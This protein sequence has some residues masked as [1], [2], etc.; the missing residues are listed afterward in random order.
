MFNNKQ[1]INNRILNDLITKFPSINPYQKPSLEKVI[2]DVTMSSQEFSD[3]TSIFPLLYSIIN[4]TGQ[5]PKIKYAKNSVASFK[6]RKG[7]EIGVL[8]TLRNQKLLNFVKI[9]TLIGLPHLAATMPGDESFKSKNPRGNFYSSNWSLGI[10]ELKP[11]QDPIFG[12]LESLVSFNQYNGGCNIHFFCSNKGV[13]N[14]RIA[15]S[16]IISSF[17]FPIGNIHSTSNTF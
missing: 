14:S 11:L 10:K 15:N 2:V 6:V 1:T 12:S 3:K 4:W 8:V 9:L 13:K 17:L 7:S 5:Y 16:F